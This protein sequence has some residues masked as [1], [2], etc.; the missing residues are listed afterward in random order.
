M[1]TLAR[2]A[3]Q[4]IS[5]IKFLKTLAGTAKA[6]KFLYEM[7]GNWQGHL[8]QLILGMGCLKTLAWTAKT[9]YFEYEMLENAERDS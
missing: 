1:K 7:L 2:T 6:A 8:K 4:L 5:G 9:V 3:K